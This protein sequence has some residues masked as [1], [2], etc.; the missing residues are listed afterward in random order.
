MTLVLSRGGLAEN[1]VEPLSLILIHDLIHEEHLYYKSHTHTHT[2]EL[3][4]GSNCSSRTYRLC[5]I[6]P[7]T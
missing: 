4:M 5:D 7:V 3:S 2:R 1:V 6:E